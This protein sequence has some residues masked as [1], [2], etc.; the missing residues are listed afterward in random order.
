MKK[1]QLNKMN[2]LNFGN[3]ILISGVIYSSRNENYICLFPGEDNQEFSVLELSFDDWKQVI[4]QTDLMETE[5]LAKDND[6][7]L[8]KTIIRK[9]TR[10]I[11]QCISWKVYKRDDYKCRYC[12]VDGTP[13]TV[14]HLVLWEVGGPTIEENLLTACRKCNKVRGNLS[15]KEWLEHP[16]YKM[17]SQNLTQEIRDKNLQLVDTLHN[18]P[19][20][21]HKRN[22]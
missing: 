2:L 13:L 18:I 12:G 11:E 10:I 14:D 3:E 22:R 21:V 5:I 20:R 4:R 9:S 19:L 8:I 6:D 1:M 17:L 7:K 15:Y 16:R